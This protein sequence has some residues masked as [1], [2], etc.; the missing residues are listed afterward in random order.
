M[1]FFK[2]QQPRIR[3][4]SVLAAMSTDCKRALRLQYAKST[5]DDRFV[6]RI[7]SM[8]CKDPKRRTAE[9]VTELAE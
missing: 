6:N 5:R 2:N 8:L 1:N 3:K 4:V 9:E 7:K